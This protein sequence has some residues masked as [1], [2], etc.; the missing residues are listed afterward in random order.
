MLAAGLVGVCFSA[1]ALQHYLAVVQN[2]QQAPAFC[3]I[4]DT[5]NCDAVA[6]S[7]YAAWR[8]IPVAGIGLLFFAA[9]V[10]LAL[11]ALM[12]REGLAALAT[13]GATAAVAGIFPSV[14]LLYVMESV[15][16]SFCI[17]CLIMDGMLGLTL[18]GWLSSRLV[19][20]RVL[21]NRV[22]IMRPLT[23][24][25]VLGG[26][27]LLL[28]VNLGSSADSAAGKPSAAVLAQA[29]AAWEHS[30]QTPLPIDPK[31]FPLWGN[32][33]AHVTIVEFSDFQCPYCR[34]AATTVRP[35]IAEYRTSVRFAFANYPLDSNCNSAV[36][37]SMHPMACLAARASLC[38]QKFGKFW[39]YHDLLFAHQK[40]L[41]R[42][43]MVSAAGQQGMSAADFTACL[44]A[45]ETETLLQQQIALG[46][47]ARI[48]GTPAF[49]INGRFVKVWQNREFL[50][51]I[52]ESQLKK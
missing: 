20:W 7:S 33:D 50:R 29:L 18:V 12:G 24:L 49:Y 37:Q 15:L 48:G 27:G 43:F 2:T 32:P 17:P 52:I 9:Q 8:G 10:L 31:I 39:A 30:P 44:D 4:N 40:E 34:L 23:A 6:A 46:Q 36:Q 45:P 19:Q 42:E 21:T 14:Y 16:Q 11:W 47:Q 3:A 51:G 22:E 38:A 1:Y 28:L 35:A 13:L 5:F 41:S 25:L 26:V